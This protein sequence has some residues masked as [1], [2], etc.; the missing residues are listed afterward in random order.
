MPNGR[1]IDWLLQALSQSQ[2]YTKPQSGIGYMNPDDRAKSL[3]QDQMRMKNAMGKEMYGGFGNRA[4]NAMR[5]I[6]PYIEWYELLQ[7]LGGSGG[8]GGM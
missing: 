7:K 4:M 6:Q 3:A 5:Q 8:G 1:N 2:N